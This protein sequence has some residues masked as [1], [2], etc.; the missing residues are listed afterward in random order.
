MS[1]SSSEKCDGHSNSRDSESCSLNTSRDDGEGKSRNLV[2]L[3]DKM[4]KD[5]GDDVSSDEDINTEEGTV[6][7]EN[8]SSLAFQTSG[9][10]IWEVFCESISD[11]R[12]V[13]KWKFA[14]YRDSLFCF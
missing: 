2:E 9:I 8:I 5:S 4:S 14:N 6:K 3:Q 1:L 13:F 11:T 10:I 12:T 7:D